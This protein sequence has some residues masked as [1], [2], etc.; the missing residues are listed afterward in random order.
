[1]KTKKVVMF[2]IVLVIVLLVASAFLALST[3]PATYY[4][5]IAL[6]GHKCPPK[7]PVPTPTR[8]PD[9]RCVLMFPSPCTFK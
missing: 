7:L 8:T 6:L 9:P 4:Q 2:L 1:M 5:C 3:Q